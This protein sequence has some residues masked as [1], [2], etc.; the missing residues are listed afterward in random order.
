MN[1]SS[2]N[3]GFEYIAG[4]LFPA[5]ATQAPTPNYAAGEAHHSELP[6]DLPHVD[7]DPSV[8]MPAFVSAAKLVEKYPQETEPIIDG[9]LRRGETANIIAPSKSGKSWLSLG[10]AFSVAIGRDWLDFPITQGR[11]LL[12]DNELRRATLASRLRKVAHAMQ[13]NLTDLQD[14]LHIEPLRGN[15]TDLLRMEAYFRSLDQKLDM[16]ILDALYR[17]LPANMSENDN[18][19][20]TER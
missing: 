12:I 4:A 14:R 3:P 2:S 5:T 11:V 1:D 18:R 10:L 17:F 15:L 16:I 9:L 13:I 7:P 19:A 20:M 8:P 6:D